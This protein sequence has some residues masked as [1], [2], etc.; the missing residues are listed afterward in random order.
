MSRYSPILLPH[1]RAMR[2]QLRGFLLKWSVLCAL[3][4]T[5]GDFMAHFGA[6]VVAA[7][8]FVTWTW[9]FLVVVIL[10]IDWLWLECSPES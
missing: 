10:S 2:R 4:F 1:N 6:I 3:L 8:C 5:L 7:A 9:S